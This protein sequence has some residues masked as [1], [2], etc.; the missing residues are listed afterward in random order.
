M[1]D[2]GCWIKSLKLKYPA[3]G[4]QHPAPTTQLGLISTKSLSS[5]TQKIEPENQLVLDS[6]FYRVPALNILQGAYLKVNVGSVCA[7]FGRNG[8]GKSTL[9]KVAAGQIQPD[10]GLVIIDGKRFY[11]KDNRRRFLDIA[12]LPQTSMLPGDMKVRTLIKSFG[13]A[14]HLLNDTLLQK[15]TGQAISS[16]SGGELRYLELSLL[17]SLNRKYVLLDEPFTGIEP[18][19]IERLCAMISGAAAEGKGVLVTDHYYQY[20]VEIADDAYLMMNKQCRHLDGEGSIAEQ[21]AMS[22]YIR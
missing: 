4:I 19:I 15:K 10:S 2:A 12:Y 18:N 7:L 6:I 22:G 14:G 11:K 1:P 13:N 5:G 8:S 9:L 16:L 17:L 21:L 20:L 3:S